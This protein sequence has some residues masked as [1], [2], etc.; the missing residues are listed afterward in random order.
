MPGMKLSETARSGGKL[1]PMMLAVF[2]EEDQMT[3]R[4]PAPI[5]LHQPQPQH[6]LHLLLQPVDVPTNLI[7]SI[8]MEMT[9]PGM[10]LSET[11][12]SGGKLE[13]MMLAV[14]VEED[15][16]TGQHLAPQLPIYVRTMMRSSSGHLQMRKIA[17]LWEMLTQQIVAISQVRVKI[18]LSHAPQVA[19]V[20]TQLEFSLSM[21]TKEA[22]TGRQ[23]KIPRQG[24]TITLCEVTAPL[25]VEFATLR[26][27]NYVYS[28]E[29]G[30]YA[31]E[32]RGTGLHAQLL[33]V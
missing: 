31:V 24:A 23:T 17:N 16:M 12:R 25:C 26:M 9:V 13:P 19:N 20:M 18:V 2:V 30:L 27:R 15:Q 11:A 1:E 28:I 8:I 3:G 32:F 6:P 14:C 22:A 33:P 10:K 21:E 7:G 29:S 4:H 5:H